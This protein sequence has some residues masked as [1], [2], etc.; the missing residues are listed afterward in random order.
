MAFKYQIGELNLFSELEIP[1]LR[2]S[3]FNKP[4]LRVITKQ[5][6][7]APQETIEIHNKNILYKDIHNNIFLISDKE[8]QVSISNKES[9]KDAAVT[10]MGIPMGYLLQKNNFQVLHGSSIASDNLAVSFIGR[11]R[12]GKSSIA[13]A[14]VNDGFKLVTED[15][16]IIKNTDIYNFSSWIKSTKSALPKKLAHSN[17][18]SIKKDSRN[19]SLFK[20]DNKYISKPITKLKVIY[21]LAD[22]SETEITQ[23][24][25]LEAFKFLFRY[26]YRE[27]EKDAKS[28]NYLTNLCKS[29]KCFLFSRDLSKPLHENKK[30]IVDHLNENLILT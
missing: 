24:E 12:A 23:L 17:Q 14:L 7:K 20:F 6:I 19:R 30:F 22:A 2:H 8:I 9:Q 21:F 29:T 25:P 16:C 28:L 15:L 3:S 4:D 1:M 11:S 18:I 27:N 10:I 5:S 13:L 26:A